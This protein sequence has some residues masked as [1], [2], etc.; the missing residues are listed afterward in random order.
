MH[1]TT[2]AF[3]ACLLALAPVAAASA[4]S[5]GPYKVLSNTKVGGDG[6]YD[7]VF[8]DS[9]NR[10]LYIPRMGAAPISRVSVFN[11]DTLAPIS[12]FPE[13]G[14]HGVAVDE[15][16][17]HAFSSSNPV[18][19]WD[20]KTLAQ[21]KTIPV[22]GRPDGIENDPYNQRI[23]VF[24]HVAPNVT[25]I[26]AKDGSVLTTFD[27]GGA[28]EQ[29]V[30]DGKGHAYVD[31]EDKASIA[32]VDTKTMTLTGKIDLAGKADGCTGLAMDTKHD[33][34][35]AACNEPN[36]M[37]VISA[38]D[39]KILTTL[40]IGKGVDG[41][42][43]N[44]ETMEAFATAGDGTLTVVKESSP[45]TFAVEQTVTTPVRART[46]TLD[47]KTGHILTIT[48]EFGPA[49]A[50]QP[51]QRPARPPMVPGTFQIVAVGK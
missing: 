4:Q 20:A 3:A 32:I 36:V 45:T 34:L 19:M 16:S 21:I 10:K 47:K 8:A 27:A 28:V 26:D 22:T 39:S 5:S 11:L 42:T 23:Y 1:R 9:A 25:V 2:L 49:P 43:F 41:A 35:F 46:I 24:S 29:S 13:T 30:F 40:P 44:P 17:G 38:K 15:K 48:A 14:G 51:G 31:L 7:Y 37:V 6:G 50:A 12:E 33:L 18:V